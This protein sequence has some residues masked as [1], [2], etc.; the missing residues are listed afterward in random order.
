MSSLSSA[1]RQFSEE[2]A[3]EVTE[4]IS[5]EGRVQTAEFCLYLSATPTQSVLSCVRTTAARLDETIADARRALR[6]RGYTGCVWVIGPSCEPNGL[7]ELL[8]ARGFGRA[9]ESPYEPE[10]EAMVLVEPPRT[11][12]GEIS[13]HLVRDYDEYLRALEIA[14]KTFEVPEDGVAGWTAAAPE[15]YK[16][17]DGVNRMTLIAYVDGRPAGFAWA[18]A[19][20]DGLLLCGSGVLPEARGR[21]AYRA[22]LEARWKVAVSLGKPVLAIHAGAMSRPVLERCGF[23]R[24]CRLELYLDPAVTSPLTGRLP[25]ARDAAASIGNT[26]PSEHPP[27]RTAHVPSA[28]APMGSRSRGGRDGLH[29]DGDVPAAPARAAAC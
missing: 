12:R 20:R 5:P 28:S 8:R 18:C 15:L 1:V 29:D 13:V 10:L 16:Q 23:E 21:G 17:Q 11:K 3:P 9:T 22:L 14:M 4:P 24:V 2:P 26:R 27:S 19:A 6:E 7:A 25:R